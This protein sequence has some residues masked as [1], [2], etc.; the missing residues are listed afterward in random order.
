MIP[1]P[2]LISFGAHLVFGKLLP[3][4]PYPVLWG[5]Q[6]GNKYVLGS[7]AGKGG[8]ASVYFN[9]VEPE[10]TSCFA[11][12]LKKGMVFFDI[13]ANVG[14]YTILAAQLVGP[15]GRVFAFEPVIR[16]IVYLYRHTILNRVKNVTI[17]A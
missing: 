4:I 8:G 2:K 11:E 9:M 3:Q 12:T 17:L 15:T 6:K 5:V 16:N 1:R 14:Y 10:Q 13:G 7:L